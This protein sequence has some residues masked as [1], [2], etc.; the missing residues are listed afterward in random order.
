MT[1][2]KVTVLVSDK[3]GDFKYTFSTENSRDRIERAL[4]SNEGF[5]Q[6]INAE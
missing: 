6:M 3:E 5:K 2:N 4:F 1:R